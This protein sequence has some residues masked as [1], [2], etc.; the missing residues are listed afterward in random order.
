MLVEN[1]LRLAFYERYQEIIKEYNQGKSLE[2]TVKAF[3]DLSNFI[4]DMNVEDARAFREKLDQETLA[5][6]DLLREG[7]QL[8][9]EEIKEVKKIATDTL[10]KLKEEKLRIERWRE[11]RQ[12]TAQIKT[13]I[14]DTL[15]WLPQN[16]YT[17]QEVSEKTITVYQHIYTNYPGGNNS[18][19]IK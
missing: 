11:S 19:Y 16:T 18:I 9:T 7:K 2:D 8:S 17:D 4:K 13:M 3:D 14:F 15:Q 12:I 1:P 10:V 6:F 5:I